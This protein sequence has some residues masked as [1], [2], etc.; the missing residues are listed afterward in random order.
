MNPQSD[1]G[2]VWT[3]EFYQNLTT[4]VDSAFPKTCPKCG[5]IY[6]DS[7]AFLTE[8][9]PVKDITLQDRSGLF[10]LEG[11]SSIA[12][13]GVFRNCICGTTIMAD[14]HDRR[15]LSSKGNE[16]RAHFETLLKTLC[17]H[18]IDETEARTELRKV[19]RGE[20]SP[21]LQAWLRDDMISD[22]PS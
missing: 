9:S 16:R 22:V 4:L 11:A 1:T 3:E 21:K 12:A 18:G 19:L 2:R 8:T 6:Q 20:D 13:I 10:S 17:D 5:I 14:F 15:D 7:H